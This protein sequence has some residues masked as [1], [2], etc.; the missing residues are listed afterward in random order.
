MKKLLLIWLALLPVSA[1]SQYSVWSD[2]IINQ[3]GQ[4]IAGITVAV[5]NTPQPSLV[6]PCGG[7]SLATLYS[8]FTGGSQ[9]NPLYTDANGRVYIYA[10]SG[11]YW[12]QVYGLGYATTT[13]PISLGG[14]GGGSGCAEGT[15]IVNNPVADQTI[16]GNYFLYL[17]NSPQQIQLIPGPLFNGL[18]ISDSNEEI[19]LSTDPATEA[20]SLNVYGLGGS[21]GE[22]C[23]GNNCFDVMNTGYRAQPPVL[24]RA[25]V[26]G[27]PA[28]NISAGSRTEFICDS[29]GTA[30]APTFPSSTVSGSEFTLGTE[31]V[32]IFTQT[33]GSPACTFA[34]PSNVFGGG[35]VSATA[36]ATSIQQFITYDGVNLYAEGSMC[37]ST[38]GCASGGSGGGGFGSTAPRYIDMY[39]QN[40]AAVPV[41]NGGEMV[42]GAVTALGGTQTS[43]YPTAT[44]NAA[45][46]FSSAA[47]AST[48]TVIYTQQN[49][50]ANAGFGGFQAFYRWDHRFMPSNSANVRY[51]M[52]FTQYNN[53]SPSPINSGVNGNASMATDTPN[54]PV[55][56]FRYSAGTDTAWQAYVGT[57]SS[58]YTAV[59]TG[60]AIDLTAPH[61]FSVIWN[62]VAYVFLIDSVQVAT[63]STNLP[64]ATALGTFMFWCGDNKNTA[65]SIAGTFYWMVETLSNTPSGGGSS[66]ACPTCVLAS[67]PGAGIAHFA[68][69]TQQVTSGAVD[70]TA[71]VTNL[72][73]IANGGTATATPALIPGTNITITGTWP[74]QTIN[75]TASGLPSVP[76]TP[77]GGIYSLIAPASGSAAWAAP[78]IPGRS[79]NIATDTIAIQDCSPNRVQYVGSTAV[80]AT[81]PTATGLGNAGCVF[82]LANK[83]TGSATVVTVTP[84][85]WTINGNSSLA[86]QQGQ[87]AFVYPDPANVTNWQADVY[88]P[89][90]TAGSNMTFTRSTTG[91]TIASSGG[92]GGGVATAFPTGSDTGAVNAYVVALSPVMGSYALGNIGCF[93]TSNTSTSTTVTVNFSSLGV[94]GIGRYGG[95]TTA[96]GDISS[97]GLNCL[98]YNGTNFELMIPAGITG[99]GGLTVLA[100]SPT[101]AGAPT[102]PTQT[103]GDNTT[104]IATDA[105]VIA[106]AG[107]STGTTFTSS[108]G[109]DETT[110]LGGGSAGK[111]TT[112]TVTTGSTVITM[113]STVPAAPHGWHCSASD[114]TNPLDIIVGT[115]AST[116]TAKLTV[117]LAITAGDVI[118]FS[119]VGY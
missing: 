64:S 61:N 72:L 42:P 56:G 107:I 115:S 66:L 49:T 22:G 108:G 33:S 112:A 21:I 53:G 39:V 54:R 4:P 5:C 8:S 96:I 46:A 87:D 117:A 37:F 35:T 17:K 6:I 40:G 71:D 59:S 95:T 51:W 98:Y 75:S 50:S 119:C 116:T 88:E 102:A 19:Q 94:K 3:S 82:K 73:P 100:N 57:T 86:L 9:I 44:D 63:I 32:M 114:I 109:L 52:G 110:L 43:V 69:S 101:L 103:L 38:G 48:S 84:V 7:S 45:V 106:N 29:A 97:S 30:F 58:L 16:N 47:T 26:S 18:Q 65:T 105:F 118:E 24:Y 34:W 25:S 90:L 10:A 20:A 55:V 81:L 62:G 104:K 11:N 111:F 77:I 74:D 27:T 2:P 13:I 80:T 83:T 36:S 1:F 89:G 41:Y 91:L 12:L 31:M 23:T 15:C 99:S 60:V 67:S 78:G 76:S 92:G 70:L 113:G 85:T 93:T 14:S 68:G 28:V 79:V